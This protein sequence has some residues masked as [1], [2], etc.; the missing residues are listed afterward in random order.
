MSHLIPEIYDN[1]VYFAIIFAISIV[2]IVLV[3]LLRKRNASIRF[4]LLKVLEIEIQLKGK[5]RK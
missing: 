2:V 5:D 1:A 4:S 3:S